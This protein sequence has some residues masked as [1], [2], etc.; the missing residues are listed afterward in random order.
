MGF[1]KNDEDK[2]VARFLNDTGFLPDGACGLVCHPDFVHHYR[3]MDE[4][5]TLYP[6][7][8]SYNG[9]P[10]NIL[11]ERQ[12]WTNYDLRALAKNLEKAGSNLYFSIF[13]VDTFN[14]CHQEWIYEHPELMVHFLRKDRV[15]T[16]HH[17]LLKRFKDGTYYEDFFIDKL[18][19]VLE[20]YGAKGIH[21]ADALTPPGGSGYIANFDFSSDFVDQF[22]THTGI[23]APADVLATMGDDSFEAEK[24]RADW[25]RKEHRLDWTNFHTTRWEMFFKKMCDRVHAIGKEVMILSMYCTDPFETV[26]CCG[27]DS[28]KIVNAGVD[29]VTA[30]ILP[31]S[32]FVVGPDDRQDPFHR[33][34]AIA[35]LTAAHLPEKGH[36]I[37]MLALSDAT[38]EWSAIHHAPTLHERDMFTMMAYRMM[39]K[40]GISRALEGYFLCL[41]DGIP[42]QD[43]DWESER[44]ELAFSA[45]AE[46]MVSPAML[47][48]EYA[49]DA[50]LPAYY[51]TR[52]WTPHKLF[53]EL[54]DAGVHCVGAVRTD[55]LDQYTGTLIVPNFDLLSEDEKQAVAKYDRGAVIA[56]ACPDFDPATYGITPAFIMKDGFSTYPITVFAYNCTVNDD[57]KEAIAPLLAEDDGAENL[58]GPMEYVKEP[59][60]G[61]LSETLTFA[62]VTTGFRD[63]MA[64]LINAVRETPFVIDKE[65]LILKLK[66]GAY[67]VYIFNDHHNKYHKAKVTSLIPIK[68][69]KIVTKFPVLAP[70]FVDS[71]DSHAAEN[72]IFSDEILQMK[73]NFI[74]KIPPA[75][76]VVLDIWEQ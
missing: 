33:Y 30:N 67:R 32:S 63:A 24:T 11:R 70:R 45:D 50:M 60:K 4:E 13:G 19:Q 10:R 5:Y 23:E 3:G 38:E 66:N 21:L 69:L 14:A 9:V 16:G 53:H 54:A 17:F 73:Q 61:T 62:K 51:H 18:C 43:W 8:C 22:L 74:V 29:Y 59:T 71:F 36:L 64:K 46:R 57:V 76:L 58:T 7:N 72:H 56:T 37:S 47:W 15:V 49:F 68:D 40:D 28:R 44:M 42:R 6:D 31:S 52:R 2:G 48:S 41:G 1:E 26:Y 34:M 12:D 55:G 39:D 65:H 35:P 20:D 75:G 27:M 25:I